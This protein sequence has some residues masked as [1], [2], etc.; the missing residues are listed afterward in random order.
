MREF[1]GG[2]CCPYKCIKFGKKKLFKNEWRW[3][4]HIITH[5][6]IVQDKFETKEQ[7]SLKKENEIIYQ[8]LLAE[9]VGTLILE[10]VIP[11]EPKEKKK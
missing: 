11:T 7:F 5:R 6:S 4:S 10:G 8:K 2:I 1:R 3:Y 9:M